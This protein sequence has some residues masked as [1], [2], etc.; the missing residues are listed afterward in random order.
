MVDVLK[1]LDIK[2]PEA[3]FDLGDFHLD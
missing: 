3:Q 2:Q 1:D